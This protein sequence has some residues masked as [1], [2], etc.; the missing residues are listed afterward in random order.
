MD[1]LSY[2]HERTELP[3]LKLNKWLG[4]QASKYYDWKKRYGKVNSHNS[5]IPRDHWLTRDEKEAICQ[6]YEE[7][8]ASG[9][10][11]L[12]YMMMDADV[13]AVSPASVYRVLKQRDLLKRFLPTRSGRKGTGF[14]QPLHVHEH[15]HID[16][17]YINICGTF[18]YLCTILDG[19]SRYVVGWGIGETMTET[20]VEVII[21]QA[22]EKFPGVSPRVISDNGPQ[23]ISKD[24]K[25][26]IRISG[27]TQARTS[28]YYPQSNGKIERWHQSLKKESIR[29]RVPLNLADAKR[30]IGEYIGV[31]NENRLHS[32]I[33]YVTPLTKM[34]GKEKEVWSERDKKLSQARAKRAKLRSLE[35]MGEKPKTGL[36]EKSSFSVSR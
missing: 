13:V 2:W 16:I 4:L 5:K 10:R 6:Y 8:P 7:H 14:E 26:Y 9:Y 11:R 17:C 3:L 34:I 1:F 23:F 25:E 19:Y 18:Y 32:G 15:W 24:F 36:T 28:P 30:I 33:G 29:Q 35:R 21:E 27:M 22:K 12:T 20:D 31:Y